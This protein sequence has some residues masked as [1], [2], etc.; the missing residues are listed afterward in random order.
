MKYTIPQDRTEP[1]ICLGDEITY[2]H[3]PEWSDATWRPLKLSLMRQRQWFDYDPHENMPVIIWLCGGAF[4]H[5]DR[6]V[7]TP[8]MAYFC[9][10]GFAVASIDYSSTARTKF[11]MQLEDI[12][13][14]IRYLKA[15]ADQLHLDADRMVI[16]GES[17]GA[18]LAAL[19]AVTGDRPEYDTGEY[20]E[21]SSAVCAAVPMYPCV[22]EVYMEGNRII[23]PDITRFISKNTPPF[24]IFHGTC[25][26]IV[27]HEE[28]EYLHDA[29]TANHVPASLYLIEGAHHADCPL[30]QTSIKEKILN[31]ICSVLDGAH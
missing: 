23:M 24:L 6:N 28:S 5:V 21:H 9:K 11:P 16:M 13:L 30:Y 1:I 29:L 12:K 18:Y 31:F 19:A 7:W 2:G 22:R 4:T 3:R 17:A 14:A 10:N 27:P 8:E 25:D 15:H 26:N 20:L